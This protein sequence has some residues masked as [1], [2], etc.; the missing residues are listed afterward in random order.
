MTFCSINHLLRI[1]EYTYLDS[2]VTS[3]DSSVIGKLLQLIKES[4]SPV[5]HNNEKNE[6]GNIISK[7]TIINDVP[8]IKFK[9]QYFE[10]IQ[11]HYH[12][13][14]MP[15]GK[16]LA[17]C[18]NQC[19]ERCLRYI[20]KNPFK[21][22]FIRPE[23]LTKNIIENAVQLNGM[24][25][26]HIPIKYW[27]DNICKMAMNQNIKSIS[28]IL[29]ITKNIEFFDYALSK[30]NNALKYIL[31]CDKTLEIYEKSF[32]LN[33]LSL[34]YAFQ[35]S[36]L[37]YDLPSKFYEIAVNQN[38]KA[39]QYVPLEKHNEELYEIALNQSCEAILL[40]PP[41]KQILIPKEKQILIPVGSS[42]QN[43][44]LYYVSSELTT[45]AIC[46]LAVQPND[47]VLQYVRKELMSDENLI[48][49]ALQFINP[50]FMTEAIFKLAV[51]QNYDVLQYIKKQTEEIRN[52]SESQ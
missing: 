11:D 18:K 51:Q 8:E 42:L 35:T 50:K 48:C 49:N 20:R 1:D 16:K 26:K 25:L 7:I 36:Y 38:W 43:D 27:D 19:E 39:L 9:I 34:K 15:I 13:L 46:N 17:T 41:E 2:K 45:E 52:L 22:I 32:Q 28:F 6:E 24:V 12:W 37:K 3:Y 14:Y 4:Y 31:D 33:G 47:D 21:I 29:N 10:K 23:N 30:N 40:I 5:M 44:K